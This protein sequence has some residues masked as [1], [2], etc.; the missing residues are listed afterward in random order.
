MLYR[1]IEEVIRY[2]KQ[3][4]VKEVMFN[5]N[6]TLLTREMIKK[7]VKA[8][9]D[10][11]ICS[12]DSHNKDTYER[13]H[14]GAKFD[15]VVYNLLKLQIYKKMNHKFGCKPSNMSVYFGPSAKVCCYEVQKNFLENLIN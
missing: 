3:Y 8:G 6:G 4:G 13:L 11:L 10:K 15:I 1:G 14:R 12:I 7:I 9:L 2:A 5:T